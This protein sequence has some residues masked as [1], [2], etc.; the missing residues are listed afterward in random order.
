MSP[1]ILA[2]RSTDQLDADNGHY[3]KLDLER[4]SPADRA[5]GELPL[6]TI[7]RAHDGSVGLVEPA[8]VGRVAAQP[9]RCGGQR[10]AWPDRMAA[11]RVIIRNRRPT[12]NVM[13]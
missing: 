2:T 12:E 7:A 11:C 9:L 5:G 8:Q 4:P 10:V 13:G 3:V 1:A 6:P